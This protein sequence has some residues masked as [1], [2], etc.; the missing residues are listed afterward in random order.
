MGYVS[1]EID[2]YNLQIYMVPTNLPCLGGQVDSHRLV[3]TKLVCG[4]TVM[5][6]VSK[7]IDRYNLHGTY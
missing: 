1:K 6:Y 7:E 5:G 2:S 3:S 4:Q